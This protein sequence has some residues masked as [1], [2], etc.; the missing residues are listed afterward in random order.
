MNTEKVAVITGA[1]QGI[2]AAL[3]TAYRK[4]GFAVVANSRSITPS[5]D[6]LVLTVSGWVAAVDRKGIDW[7]VDGLAYV[8]RATC[9]IEDLI[10][11][12]FVD[13]I[14]NRTAEWLYAVGLWLRNVQTGRLREYVMYIV[15][16]T[17]TLFI[18]ISL[19]LDYVAA[20]I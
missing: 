4:L 9:W 17:V 19:Y 20:V 18:V 10:D 2:G 16:A 15:I 13:G 14:V 6:P 1:S 8:T 5:D 3:V 11:R 7:V 12:W